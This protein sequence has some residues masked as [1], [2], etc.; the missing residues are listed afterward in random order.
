MADSR[1]FASVLAG[2]ALLCTCALLAGCGEG[3]SAAASPPYVARGDRICATQLALLARLPQPTT[4][5]QAVTYL[6]HVLTAL[7]GEST[8]LRTLQPPPSTRGELREALADTSR[9]SALLSGFLDRLRTGIVEITMFGQIQSQ[10]TALR[11]QIDAH[12]RRAHLMRC[13]Q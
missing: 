4:P 11:T 7:H 3:S 6:P 10:S 12:F 5:D 1:P 2:C 13:V 9:L 8:Q